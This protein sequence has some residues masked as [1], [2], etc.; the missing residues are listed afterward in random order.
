MC[1]WTTSREFLFF[2]N[3]SWNIHLNFFNYQSLLSF[4]Q[5]IRP[6]A[7][8]ALEHDFFRRVD[9]TSCTIT[10]SSADIAE[11]TAA[12]PNLD[13]YTDGDF[14]VNND[15]DQ[16]I[17]NVRSRNNPIDTGYYYQS[18]SSPDYGQHMLTVD[19]HI[20]SVAGDVPQ[21]PI[22]VFSWFSDGWWWKLSKEIFF[23]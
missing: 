13:A 3:Y 17:E 12:V 20:S 2:C 18:W 21:S 19:S 9:H 7:I 16:K 23:V 6:T 14:M 22:D 10:W 4:K 11:A 8:R 15:D 5:S 1:Y